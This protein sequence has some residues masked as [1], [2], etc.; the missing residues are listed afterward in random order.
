MQSQMK[1]AI[2]TVKWLKFIQVIQTTF[3]FEYPV[4]SV[5]LS[6]PAPRVV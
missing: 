5:E 4:F 2:I 3:R 6:G 1:C